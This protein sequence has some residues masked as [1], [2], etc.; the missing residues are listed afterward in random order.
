[1]KRCVCS[2]LLL[3]I[4]WTPYACRSPDLSLKESQNTLSTNQ[5]S[6]LHLSLIQNTELHS[7]KRVISLVPSHSEWIYTLGA[8]SCLIARSDYCD[9]PPE[10]KEKPSI[11]SLFPINIEKIISLQASDLLMIDG[12]EPFKEQMQKLGIKVHNLQNHT[13]RDYWNHILYLGQLLGKE[14]TAQEWIKK[15]KKRLPTLGKRSHDPKSIFVEIWY[16]PL[17]SVGDQTYIAD[18]LRLAGTEVVVKEIGDWPQVSL[19]Q[20]LQWNPEVLLISSP[21]LY[22]Q[23]SQKDEQDRPVAWR[24][25]KAVQDGHVYLLS[26]RFVRP[27]P[28][29]IDDILWLY[30][31]LYL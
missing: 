23:L 28:R 25:I 5:T 9:Y 14:K 15:A 7:K 1:M 31:K 19:E 29:L 4:F 10:I 8:E 17:M 13:I 27:G 20:V 3:M 2:M 16:K 24:K 26:G 22:K 21:S 30:Q 6:S 11:G 18:A 12:H